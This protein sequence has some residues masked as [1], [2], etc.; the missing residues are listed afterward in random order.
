MLTHLI[1][2]DKHVAEEE[3]EQKNPCNLTTSAVIVT[4]IEPH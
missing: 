2:M 3:D 4:I 1:K